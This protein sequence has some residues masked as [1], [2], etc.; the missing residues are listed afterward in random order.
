MSLLRQS[1]RFALVGV[2]QWAIDW[3][4]LVVLSRAGLAIATAN[5]AG[6]VCGALAGFWLNGSLTFADGSGRPGWRQFG[7][8]VVLWAIN[9]LLSTTAVFWIDAHAGLYGAWLAKPLVE[10]V[11]ALN[12][13]LFSRWWV[14]R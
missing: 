11:L 14:Y 12:T 3:G 1:R 2:A 10:G 5:I 6:R 4:L 13:F 9:T 7:R 8:Y